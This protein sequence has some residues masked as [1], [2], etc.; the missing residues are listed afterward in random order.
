MLSGR[1]NIKA[2]TESTGAQIDIEDDGTVNIFA[3]NKEAMDMALE[4]V[5][6]ITADVE[7]GTIYRAKVI[8]LKD[9]GAI[10]ELIPGKEG[11]LH[12]SEMAN[13]RVNKVTD[14]CKEGDI[15]TVKVMGVDDRG[16]IKLSRKA[17]L[18]EIG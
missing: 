13:Y 14:I 6:A 8:G 3:I 12:I 9:F 2:I 5:N 17:A 16:K 7:I 15:V 18:A 11:L 10:V 4:A 1:S